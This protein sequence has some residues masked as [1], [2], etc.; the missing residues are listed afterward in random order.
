[1]STSSLTIKSTEVND[2]CLASAR[3]I[4]GDYKIVFKDK[5]LLIIDEKTLRRKK[6]R[7]H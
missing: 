3:L 6:Q 7:F 1:M 5:S 4:N 2:D